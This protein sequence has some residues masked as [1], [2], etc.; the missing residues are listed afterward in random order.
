MSG[1]LVGMAN[2][3]SKSNHTGKDGQVWEKLW[4]LEEM[5]QT[6]ANWSLAADSGVC[7]GY[8]LQVII[9]FL[10]TQLFLMHLTVY[11]LVAEAETDWQA[12]SQPLTLHVMGRAFT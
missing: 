8:Y 3:P 4:T 10:N 11:H 7:F 2:V 5:R 9:Q 1:L 12:G 6:S